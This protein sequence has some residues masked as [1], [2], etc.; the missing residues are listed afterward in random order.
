MKEDLWMYKCQGWTSHAADILMPTV[1]CVWLFYA[2]PQPCGQPLGSRWS[3]FWPIR[4][5]W[6]QELVVMPIEARE[7]DKVGM[8]VKRDMGSTFLHKYFSILRI[9]KKL[10]E[11]RTHFLNNLSTSGRGSYCKT[12]LHD[13][14]WIYCS[15]HMVPTSRRHWTATLNNWIASIMESPGKLI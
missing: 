11:G 5:A 4:V 14:Q 1:V 8:E 15:T 2:I 12:S 13:A 3:M 9:D 10:M 7:L 6:C